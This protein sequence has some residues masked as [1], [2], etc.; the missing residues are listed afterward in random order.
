[1]YFLP[2]PETPTADF[3]G[4]LG[5]SGHCLLMH[6]RPGQLI[7]LFFIAGSLCNSWPCIVLCPAYPAGPGPVPGP[8]SNRA[9]TDHTLSASASSAAPPLGHV[10]SL[11][12]S[13]ESFVAAASIPMPT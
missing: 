10:A 8:R 12:L 11:L 3:L 2:W 1:M 13:A 5:S 9:S 4:S 7:E 6:F